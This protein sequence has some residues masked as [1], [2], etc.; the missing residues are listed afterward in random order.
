MKQYEDETYIVALSGGKDSTAMAIRLTEVEPKEYIYICTPTGDELPEMYTHWNKLEDI[1]G[2]EIIRLE[3]PG[4]L[5]GCMEKNNAIPNWRMR[6]CTRQ[7]K[8]EIME[9]W[10]TDKPNPV[11]YVGLRADEAG[12]EGGI[13]KNAEVDFPFRRW[14][15][16]LKEVMTYLDEKDVKIP[17]RT[18][19]ARCFFQRL[20]EWYMLWR[21]Y[22]EIYADAV[23][24]EKLY[25]HTY[26][27]ET[28]D[29]WPGALDN[30]AMEFKSGRI[31]MGVDMHEDLFGFEANQCRVCSL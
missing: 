16:G 29:A 31:P 26:R 12:R 19:C 18:D 20:G 4:G 1:L 21:D 5:K 2:Q 8:I 11:L 7:L 22:P 25:G 14:D 3:Y 30:L 10:M 28:K 24:D 23:A 27:S 17:R 15:W 9:K 13:Y 6:F